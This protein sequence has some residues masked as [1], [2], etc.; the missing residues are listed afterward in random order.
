MKPGPP[1]EP[2]V[3][4]LLKGNPGRRRLKDEPEPTIPPTCPEPPPHITGYAADLWWE[5]APELHHLLTRIDI[6]ALACYCHSFGQWR[7]AAETLARMQANDPVMN[8]QIIKTKY[9][10][11]VMNL[12]VSLARKHAAD[13]VRYANEFG[14]SAAA[15]SRLSAAGY[16][17]ASSGKFSGLLSDGS[18]VPM[19]PRGDE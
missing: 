2:K 1:P 7:M 17:P 8:A 5:T 12:L 6:P 10:D 19:K 14:L 16:A 11:A 3:L 18:V 4:K 15:R 9:G 13:M